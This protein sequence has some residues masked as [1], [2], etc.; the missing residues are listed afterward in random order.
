MK[1][2]YDILKT[3]SIENQQRILYSFTERYGK[4]YSNEPLEKEYYPDYG[5]LEILCNIYKSDV[6]DIYYDPQEMLKSNL[7]EEWA[8]LLSYFKRKINAYS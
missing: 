7:A 6:K 2:F 8:E 4:R 3:L 5:N 1:D